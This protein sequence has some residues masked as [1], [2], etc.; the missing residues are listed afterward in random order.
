MI[1][2]LISYIS[3][4]MNETL[5]KFGL[6]EVMVDALVRGCLII[7]VL[8]FS[9]IAYQIVQGPLNRSL[10]RFSS[11]T[12]QQW[13][14][15]LVDKH[16]FQRLLN[17][18]PLILIYLLTSPILAG[19]AWLPLSQT[20]I[21][22]LFLIAGMMTIDALLNALV[23]IYA[24]ST[25]SKEISITPFVQ[26]LKLGL[27]FVTGILLLSLLLQKTPLY[28]LSGLG[29]LTAV[30]MFVFKDILMGFV[31]GIQLIANKMVA[32][33]DW[34]EMPKYGAD[35]DVIEITLTTV[36]VQ[37][38]D[39]TITTIPTYAL[40]NESFK[41]WRNMNLSGGRRIKRYVNI[42][43]SSIK[44]CDSEML[45]RFTRI[46][47]ISKD[48]QARQ[49]EIKVHNKEHHVDESTLVNGRRLTNIGVFR[50]Y[51]EAYL[52]QHPLIH[53]DMTF[54]IRQL[55]PRE[56]GLPIEIYVFCKDTDWT[57][58][59]SVQADIFDHILAV[60]PEFNLRVFQEPSGSDF[61]KILI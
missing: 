50:S 56:N 60:V 40:I 52:R 20:L 24:N 35:G 17:F 53:N 3:K 55:S 37:N 22:I 43:L 14:N 12:S 18:I 29:A 1:E 5:L 42:D 26:V 7:L 15:V 61:K 10:E 41:N 49:E 2:Y 48:I 44:F 13:D 57:V 4:I 51:V 6:T 19:T 30:L 31:A 58:Y 8:G 34:I 47:L 38:F 27:Y 45:E 32:P 21:S 16:V 9:W 39:N 54:L 11:F 28:F 36:K 59:E 46:Q 25:I 23:A 33:K